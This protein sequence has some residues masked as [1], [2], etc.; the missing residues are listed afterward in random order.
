MENSDCIL[1]R[2]VKAFDNRMQDDARTLWLKVQFT[3]FL[4]DKINTIVF[5]IKIDDNNKEAF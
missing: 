2:L 1:T 4:N 5:V 3:I